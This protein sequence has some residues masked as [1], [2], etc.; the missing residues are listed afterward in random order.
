V[1]VAKGVNAR[2][3]VGVLVLPSRSPVVPILA[4]GLLRVLAQLRKVEGYGP[5]GTD[6]LSPTLIRLPPPRNGLL[7][8]LAWPLLAPLAQLELAWR[9]VQ[10][11]RRTR[12]LVFF[13]GLHFGPAMVIA[14]LIGMRILYVPGG[15]PSRTGRW[16]I[17][18]RLRRA[19]LWIHHRLAHA[20]AFESQLEADAVK[21]GKAVAGA[22]RAIDV[23]APQQDGLRDQVLFLARLERHKGVEEFLEVARQAPDLQF[24]VAGAGRLAPLVQ[25]AER[26]LANLRFAGFVSEEQKWRLLC[27]ARVL[28]LPARGGDGV[29][30][31]ILE[32]FSAG[33]PVLASP[34]G[35]IPA[36]VV[37]GTTGFLLPAK[38][39]VD[40]VGSLRSMLADP[41]L[42][43][44]ASR[45]KKWAD[46]Q[47]GLDAATRRYR[48]LLAAVEATADRKP[49]ATEVSA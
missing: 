27:R 29:P 14:R 32:A 36:V 9:V 5:A 17:A 18:R 42:D 25:A 30:T 15:D 49:G 21:T 11:R 6:A 4:D 22:M 24:T 48:R 20:I 37:D 23:P 43:R 44:V 1:K 3:T 39:R 2:P 35:G 34:V 28:I 45:A 31:I 26:E 38:D 33:T 12:T 47:L 13:L 19:V 41:R 46:E 7:P 16:P 10:L 8:L 40:L